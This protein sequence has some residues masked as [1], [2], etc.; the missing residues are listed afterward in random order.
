MERATR[1]D[2]RVETVSKHANL[3]VTKG[4]SV[5]GFTRVNGFICIERP[6]PIRV[7]VRVRVRG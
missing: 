4:V 6:G 1:C 2:K 3:I 5:S 7:R